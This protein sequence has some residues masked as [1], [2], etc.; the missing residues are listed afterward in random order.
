M[1]IA[2]H[3][4]A[5]VQNFRYDTLKND[6]S[7]NIKRFWFLWIFYKF[8]IEYIRMRL[9]HLM[10]FQ[11]DRPDTN[12]G[13]LNLWLDSILEMKKQIKRLLLFW[14]L[15]LS[16]LDID[17]FQQHKAVIKRKEWTLSRRVRSRKCPVDDDDSID[18]IRTTIVDYSFNVLYIRFIVIHTIDH[19]PPFLSPK[20]NLSMQQQCGFCN[21]NF[22][23][24]KCFSWVARRWC[25]LNK[26]V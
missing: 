8:H 16:L 22:V 7:I 3:L 14:I 1:A 11:F 5:I 26:S 15:H 4:W 25:L 12:I 13:T 21:N 23:D 10:A 24:E 20:S 19:C 18:R 9:H 17:Y 6:F 2:T